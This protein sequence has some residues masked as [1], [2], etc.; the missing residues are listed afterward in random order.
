MDGPHFNK[1]RGASFPT[2]PKT[3]KKRKKILNK[4]RKKFNDYPLPN[5]DNSELK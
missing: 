2:D 3:I 4:A 1:K 5:Q